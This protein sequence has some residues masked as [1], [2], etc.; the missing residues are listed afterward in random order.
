M[1]IFQLISQRGY[2]TPEKGQTALKH[3]MGSVQE[4]DRETS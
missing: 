3:G 1:S 2:K 4:E